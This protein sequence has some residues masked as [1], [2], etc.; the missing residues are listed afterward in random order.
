MSRL[1]SRK[2]KTYQAAF[3]WL[4]GITLLLVAIF[5][6]VGKMPPLQSSLQC[7]PTSPLQV[8]EGSVAAVEK[9]IPWTRSMQE[10]EPPKWIAGY[11]LESDSVAEGDVTTMDTKDDDIMEYPWSRSL[12]GWEPPKWITDYVEWHR[13][14]RATH[15][16]FNGDSE[17]E[18]PPLYVVYCRVDRGKFA[19]TRKSEYGGLHDRLGSLPFDL[20][21]ANQTKRL[22]FYVWDTPMSL[23]TF[24]V[25]NRLNWSLDMNRRDFRLLLKSAPNFFKSPVQPW[26]EAF[27]TETVPEAIRNGRNHKIP[28]FASFANAHNSEY[29]LETALRELGETDMI[30]RTPTFGWIW[31][32]LFKP[33]PGLES[34]LQVS[35][36]AM[37]LTKGRYTAIHIRLHYPVLTQEAKKNGLELK[38]HDDPKKFKSHG[39]DKGDGGI[40]FQGD[41]KKFAVDIGLH[42]V[43]CGRNLTENDEEPLYLMSDANYLADYLGQRSRGGSQNGERSDDELDQ[44]ADTLLSHVTVVA[45]PDIHRRNLHID[46]HIGNAT[47]FFPVFADL[48]LAMESRCI[49]F[50]YGGFGRFARQLTN[51]TCYSQHQL[52]LQ[53]EWYKGHSLHDTSNVC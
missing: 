28:V 41:G 2:Q 40:V 36:N 46:G 8:N 50:G 49:T 37:N 23:E 31:H 20:F 22:L 45:R 5:F 51:N 52:F 14:L 24:L 11:D 29:H 19:K 1:R 25:P 21:M 30:H 43:E 9:V 33:S 42:S 16:A 48:Y 6:E 32:E 3:E 39:F 18:I 44:H 26:F 27:W 35:R 12:Q 4:V 53:G 13:K 17:A 15:P 10:W 7:S 34:Y 47:D 38:S